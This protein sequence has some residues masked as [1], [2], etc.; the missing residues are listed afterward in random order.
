MNKSECSIEKMIGYFIETSRNIT[1]LKNKTLIN[2]ITELIKLLNNVPQ[3]TICNRINTLL[4][5][6][7]FK[8]PEEKYRKIQSNYIVNYAAKIFF[9]LLNYQNKE[10]TEE[11]IIYKTKLIMD[12]YPKEDM[13]YKATKDLIH[14]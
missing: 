11:D 12:K 6:R 1:E 4:I 9:D 7:Y 10:F 14:F 8:L 3:E 2:Y 5:D 13:I